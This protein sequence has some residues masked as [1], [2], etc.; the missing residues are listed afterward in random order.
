MPIAFD[1]ASEAHSTAV[2]SITKA[3]TCTGLNRLLVAFGFVNQGYGVTGITYAGV[4]MTLMQTAINGNDRIASFYLVAP[5]TG[6]NNA[7]LSL[8]GAGSGSCI[9]MESLTGVLQTG[10]PDA[11]T[12]AAQSATPKTSS[13]TVVT[14]GSWVVI[15]GR[16]SGSGGT[17]ASTNCTDR[18]LAQDQLGMFDSGGGQSAGNFDMTMTSPSSMFSTMASFAPFPATEKHY[19]AIMAA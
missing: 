7:V 4:A 16:D 9:A 6:T 2:T 19:S 3:H 12:T 1:A 5:A 14:A 15:C 17:A 10:Q 18:S 13:I 8:G 11:S